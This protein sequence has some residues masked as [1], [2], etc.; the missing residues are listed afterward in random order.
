MEH[1]ST[2][3]LPLPSLQGRGSWALPRPAPASTCSP[4]RGSS[5]SAPALSRLRE[6]ME[7]RWKWVGLR[8]K[9]RQRA[10]WCSISVHLLGNH[11]VHQR[12]RAPVAWPRTMQGD[13]KVQCLV[14]LYQQQPTKGTH[15]RGSQRGG[16]C[17]VGVPGLDAGLVELVV[18]LCC[19]RGACKEGRTHTHLDLSGVWGA[20]LSQQQPSVAR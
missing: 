9:I 2:H 6:R 7:G 13:I 10:G 16:V 4:R 11:R 17:L 1:S 5:S 19:S 20:A 14:H 8:L 12:H 15:Q 18:R 3:L